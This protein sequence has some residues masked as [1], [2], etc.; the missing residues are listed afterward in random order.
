M[1]CGCHDYLYPFNY[2]LFSFRAALPFAL[3]TKVIV[4]A[5]LSMMASIK[6]CGEIFI[7]SSKK[8]EK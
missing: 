5:A 6:R 4:R 8:S 2:F 1:L 7:K 3:N